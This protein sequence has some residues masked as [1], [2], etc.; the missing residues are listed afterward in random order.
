M[1]SVLLQKIIFWSTVPLLVRVLLIIVVCLA[2]LVIG[3]MIWSILRN[4]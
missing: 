2:L 3:W 1:N 4:I